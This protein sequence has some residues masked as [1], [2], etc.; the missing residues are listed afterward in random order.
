MLNNDISLVFGNPIQFD[1]SLLLEFSGRF[2]IV[3][4]I[5]RKKCFFDSKFYRFD[6][7]SRIIYSPDS[8][9]GLKLNF[10]FVSVD[11]RYL[12]FIL[13]VM[14]LNVLKLITDENCHDLIELYASYLKLEFEYSKRRKFAYFSKFINGK[15]V[16]R[17]V[18]ILTD[19]E[20]SS[21]IRSEL[22]HIKLRFNNAIFYKKSNPP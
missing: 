15:E 8:I 12:L 6:S 22:A 18:L 17:R 10:N 13:S 5:V 2:K 16:E 14:Q 3:N 1:P 20:Y 19:E 11:T 7:N 9:V 4:D 21:S